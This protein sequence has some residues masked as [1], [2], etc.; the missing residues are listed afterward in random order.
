LAGYDP[1]FPIQT[2]WVCNWQVAI[3]KT[4]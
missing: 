2:D 3:R 1:S 4:N